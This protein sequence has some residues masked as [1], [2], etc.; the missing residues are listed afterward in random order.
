MEIAIRP[1]TH[2]DADLKMLTALDQ[3]VFQIEG[4]HYSMF[5][6]ELSRGG[7]LLAE[8]KEDEIIIGYA[9]YSK[10][11][12]K[13]TITNVAVLQEYR[14]QGIANLLLELLFN[15]LLAKKVTSISLVV[16]S[17]NKPAQLLYKRFGFEATG[18]IRIK[19][20]EYDDG[21]AMRVNSETLTANL[22]S[23]KKKKNPS[24]N[25][26]TDKNQTDKD[27]VKGMQKLGISKNGNQDASTNKKGSMTFI[28]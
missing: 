1:I 25:K 12:Q 17:Q 16:A 24:T 13:A 15:N 6:S 19:Y 14:R 22:E 4:W 27:L 2:S 20:Y 9:M 7:G 5:K 11:K 18:E 21:I 10:K 28:I 23:R 8:L 3:I 26:N